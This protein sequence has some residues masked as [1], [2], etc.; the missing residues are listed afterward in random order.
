MNMT[1]FN[2]G[3]AIIIIVSIASNVLTWSISSN[4]LLDDHEFLKFKTILKVLVVLELIIAINCFYALFLLFTA[5]HIMSR[6]AKKTMNTQGTQDVCKITV[7]AILITLAI[8]AR[9]VSFIVLA[10]LREEDYG[11]FGHDLGQRDAWSCL[12][13]TISLFLLFFAN[14]IL[15]NLFWGYVINVN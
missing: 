13:A 3:V 15:L 11:P 12:F 10:F 14:L 6:N 4:T 2:I 7:A 1:C 8:L 9:A 5:L